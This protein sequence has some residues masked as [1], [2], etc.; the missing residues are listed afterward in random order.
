MSSIFHFFFPDVESEKNLFRLEKIHRTQKKNIS[1]TFLLPRQRHTVRTSPLSGSTVPLLRI[2][3]DPRLAL[4]PPP[5]NGGGGG[6]S[7][8]DDS[9][10]SSEKKDLPG[11]VAAATAAAVAAAAEPLPPSRCDTARRSFAV[12]A[13]GAQKSRRTPGFL[14][15]LMSGPKK[16]PYGCAGRPC[17]PRCCRRRSAGG[18]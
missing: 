8:D 6:D 14:P 13:V 7:D 1:S 5:Q 16:P 2:K 18:T 17:P 4:P 12:V 11:A 9:A 10:G 3:M 15:A